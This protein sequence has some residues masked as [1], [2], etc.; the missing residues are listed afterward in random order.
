MNDRNRNPALTDAWRYYEKGR[1][2]N[3]S[4]E[5]N[6][7][8][9]VNTNLEFFSGNQWINMPETDALK[10]LPRPTFNIIKR[11]ASLFIASLT[12]AVAKVAASM[13][14]ELSPERFEPPAGE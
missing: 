1:L 5:P 3:N 8:R 4:L 14:S 11:V 12:S 9:L 7:Y 6:Q 13:S 2:Y 10:R